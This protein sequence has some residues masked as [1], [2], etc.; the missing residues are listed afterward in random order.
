MSIEADDLEAKALQ[1]KIDNASIGLLEHC[2]SVLILV[3]LRQP[4]QG[5]LNLE[6]SKGNGFA[7]DG[8]LR[9]ALC[10]RETMDRKYFEQQFDNKQDSP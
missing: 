5:T 6:A 8:S 10:R 1:E 2:D 9:Y 7:V 3:T 4:E